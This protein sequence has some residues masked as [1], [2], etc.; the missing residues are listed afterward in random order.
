MENELPPEL[1]KT[2]AL[3]GL[4]KVIHETCIDKAPAHFTYDNE[5]MQV[6]YMFSMY[7]IVVELTGDSYQAVKSRKELASHVLTRALLEAVV[8]LF[9]VIKDPNYVNTL[10]QQ[11][12]TERGKKIKS[13]LKKK[14]DLITKAGRTAEFLE[15]TLDKIEKLRDP[16]VDKSSIRKRFE[17]AGMEGYYDTAY[18]YLCDYVHHDASAII[19]RHIGLTVRPLDEKGILMLTN[20]I[21]ELILKSSIAVHEFLKTGQ[22]N[23]FEDLQQKW[24]VALFGKPSE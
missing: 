9:D 3:L 2:D 12:M 17:D 1:Q 16:E 10:F 18:A 23:I 22:G 14:P 20:L 24:Q 15:E 13:L 4:L 6:P 8:V 19:N 7:S 21:S 11:S 5:N